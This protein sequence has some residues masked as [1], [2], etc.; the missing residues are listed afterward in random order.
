MR[1]IVMVAFMVL[2]AT[3]ALSQRH[4]RA[5][6]VEN[7]SRGISQ[8]SNPAAKAKQSFPRPNWMVKHASSSIGLKPDQWLRIAFVPRTALADVA[9]PIVSVPAERVFAVEF[10]AKTERNSRLMQG[11]RSGCSY[12]HALMPDTAKHPRPEL[13]VAV[14]LSP[15]TC[16]AVGGETQCQ[17]PGS[18]RLERRRRTKIIRR[19]G[20]RL[21]VPVVYRKRRMVCR[22]ALA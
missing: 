10:S 5:D 2:F 20:D 15:G 18:F 4:G 19:E 9:I 14:A 1:L 22:F 3:V 11:P 6:S 7:Y 8:S 17:T 21:R 13:A 16:F 12:A